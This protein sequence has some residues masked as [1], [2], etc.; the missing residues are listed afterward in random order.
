VRQGFKQAPCFVLSVTDTVK[1]ALRERERGG[2]R[3]LLSFPVLV[4][5]VRCSIERGIQSSCVLSSKMS[6][7]GRGT[8]IAL[9]FLCAQ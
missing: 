2:G 8:R 3:E 9:K 6:N 7:R 4:C 5:S 1:H